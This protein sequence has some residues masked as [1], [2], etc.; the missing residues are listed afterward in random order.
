MAFDPAPTLSKVRCPILALIG[1]KDVQVPADQ[2]IAALKKALR[3]NRRARVEKLEG[4]NH[5]FQH[6]KTGGPQ[7][8]TTIAET[9]APSV[10]RLIDEWIAAE[11]RK[12]V[13]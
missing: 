5:L 10:L 9:M 3:N 4:L 7:E 8:Y 2:N 6:A 13:S 11:T 12:R 1:D